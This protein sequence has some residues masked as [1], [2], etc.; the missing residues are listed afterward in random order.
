MTTVT[1]AWSSPTK[2]QQ[3]GPTN[4]IVSQP[5]KGIDIPVEE[6]PIL[7]KVHYRMEQ[8][9]F[10]MVKALLLAFAIIC[11]LTPEVNYKV[12]QLHAPLFDMANIPSLRAGLFL[13]QL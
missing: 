9:G 7:F 10:V 6:V 1:G 5:T 11:R 12:V 4:Y 3:Q 13:A 2:V 8:W